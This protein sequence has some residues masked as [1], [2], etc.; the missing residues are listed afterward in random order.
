MG[1]GGAGAGGHLDEGVGAA[2]GGGAGQVEDGGVA[3]ESGFGLGPVGLEQLAFD[4]AQ[5]GVD[6]LPR[7]R[8]EGHPSEPHAP[9]ALRE[10]QLAGGTVVV[11]ALFG[12]VGVD[13]R[14]PVVTGPLEGD[15]AVVEREVEEPL[16]SVGVEGLGG[17]G[18]T[19]CEQGS[20]VRAV[21]LTYAHAC[22]MAGKV[23]RARAWRRR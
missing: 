7:D 23:R 14:A 6:D 11:G 15:E 4:H 1:G 19:G 3:V 17:A 5:G 20:D 22:S 2:L 18:G 13:H 12:A 21:D 9:E 8:I 10:V 16:M